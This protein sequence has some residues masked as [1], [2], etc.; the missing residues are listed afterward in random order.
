[1]T[2]SVL[3]T[4]AN[5]VAASDAH[6]LL[7]FDGTAIIQ[8]A[9]FLFVALMAS[10]FIFRPFLK[11]RDER[12]ARTT[13]AREEASAMI[14]EADSSLE[15]YE[16]QLAAARDRANRERQKVR[17]EA[18]EF[19]RELDDKTRKEITETTLAAEAKVTAET[20]AARDEL[21]PKASMIG[22]EITSNLLGR[23]VKA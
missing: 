14:A 6:P 9:I 11:M 13:G 19:Q 2:D 17:A 1:M 18:A 22:H 4:V 15:K 8:F 5:T 16:A 21:L 7:D 20:S 10:K 12:D 3:G 23:E